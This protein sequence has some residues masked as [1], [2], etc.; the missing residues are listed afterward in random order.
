LAVG[1][2]LVDRGSS[3]TKEQA[4]PE[5]IEWAQAQSNALILS[6]LQAGG[7]LPVWNKRFRKETAA[8]R[9]AK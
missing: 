9:L 6:R 7:G 4:F 5:K 8:T 3:K 2:L 1:V